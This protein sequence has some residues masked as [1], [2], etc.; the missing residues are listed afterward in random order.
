MWVPLVENNEYLDEGAD[1]F[2]KKHI[3]NIFS[4][5]PDIDTILLACT[6]YPLLKE[7]IQKYLPDGVQLISQGEIV[8]GS[9]KDYLQ[10]HPEM[11]K[12]ITRQGN[13]QFY[14]TDSAEDFDHHA[15]NFFG[16]PIAS[17]HIDL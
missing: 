11:E 17:K 4:K 13:L 16:K 15:T 1:Y 8:A 5:N 3:K 7:K 12:K 6:H 2:I 14:T 9:L 10:R